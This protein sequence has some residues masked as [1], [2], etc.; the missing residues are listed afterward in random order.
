MSVAAA[1]E[2]GLRKRSETHA[3]SLIGKGKVKESAS[4]SGP[5]ASRENSYIEEWGFDKF[6]NW[7]LGMN[8]ESDEDTKGR[9]R[10]P[11]SD[12]FETVSLNGLRAIRSRS[13]QTGETGIF[14]ASGRLLAAAK[15]KV[16]ASEPE[17][18]R[19]LT[20]Q[21]SIGNVDRVGGI[22]HDVVI[23][24]EGEARG[25][26]MMVSRLTLSNA[27]GLLETEPLPAYISHTG[28]FADRLLDEIGTFS[29]FY[30]DG[31][32]IRAGRF[33]VLPSFRANEPE[34][35]DRLFDLAERL[36]QAFGISIVFEGSVAWETEDGAEDFT[37]FAEIPDGA[38]YPL[39]TIQ[40]ERI[41]SADFVDTPAATSSL[42]SERDKLPRVK[43]L[44]SEE[45]EKSENVVF[46][47]SASAELERRQAEAAEADKAEEKS[48]K[49]PGKKK[50]LETPDAD[51]T[52]E[53]SEIIAEDEAAEEA[54]EAPAE[55]A[56]EEMSESDV[57]I[58]ERD[59]LIGDQQERI[60]ELETQIAVLKKVFSGSEEIADDLAIAEEK[61]SADVKA[62]TIAAYMHANP[63]H[64]KLTAVLQVAKS[65]PE[66]FTN[67]NN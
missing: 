35:F 59:V 8:P 53:G 56:A 66:L 29:E 67:S 57:K 63:S 2:T 61:T 42:F 37:G 16:A 54:E 19:R 48:K 1:L 23:L 32:K 11:F 9:Y 36:P 39:P 10:Y 62:D 3:A 22:L 43:E 34:R 50:K 33:E 64:S 55:E 18:S 58:A 27:L 25:H 51:E 49:K 12:D 21:A 5:S 60:A 46:A 41:N 44:M 20:F 65:S 40:P 13:A 17:S 30:Q 7:F 52:A 15:K 14:D 31:D 4:W 6:S 38:L 28:A 45:I 26:R 47:E 24:E